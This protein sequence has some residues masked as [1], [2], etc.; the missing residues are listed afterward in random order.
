MRA[1]VLAELVLRTVVLYTVANGI[2]GLIV[3]H[4]NPEVN[5][6]VNALPETL[7]LVLNGGGLSVIPSAFSL[8]PEEKVLYKLGT[9]LSALLAVAHFAQTD[10]YTFALSTGASPDRAKIASHI[11]VGLMT[12]LVSVMHGLNDNKAGA[13]RTV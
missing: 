1:G 11:T 7:V 13:D 4:E 2:T 10:L 3:P 6:I 5:L 8:T 12:L 9:Q